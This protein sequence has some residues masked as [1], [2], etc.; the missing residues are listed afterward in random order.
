MRCRSSGMFPALILTSLLFPCIAMPAWQSLPAFDAPVIAPQSAPCWHQ[1]ELY[2]VGRTS[3]WTSEDHEESHVALWVY[4]D[5]A[6]HV[7]RS[8]GNLSPWLLASDGTEL[9]V[10]D[11][12]ELHWLRDRRWR[13]EEVRVPGSASALVLWNGRVVAGGEIGE[14]GT[15]G[16]VGVVAWNGQAWASLGGGIGGVPLPRVNAMMADGGAVWVAGRFERA[17]DLPA[18]NVAR[19]DGIGWDDLG[20][21]ADGEI[22]AMAVHDGGVAVAGTFTQI[23][24]RACE[25]LALWRDGSWI[26]LPAPSVPTLKSADAC[27]LPAVTR[28]VSVR[29]GLLALGRFS[30]V[31]PS[32]ETVRDVAVLVDGKWQ[33][34]LHAH[35]LF[36]SGEQ[37]DWSSLSRRRLSRIRAVAGEGDGGRVAISGE[38]PAEIDLVAQVDGNID[39]RATWLLYPRLDR[40]ATPRLANWGN[41]LLLLGVDYIGP[42]RVGGLGRL[43]TDGWEPIGDWLGPDGQSGCA[44]KS[45]VEW[46]GQ[47]VVAGVFD[48]VA[49]RPA[50]YVAAFDGHAWS[51]LAGGVPVE[52]VTAV[53][54]LP[55]RR[56]LVVMTDRHAA[57]SRAEVRL[58]SWDG[59]AWSP[60][61]LP[62]LLA[63]A[64][65]G[66]RAVAADDTIWVVA[67]IPDRSQAAFIGLHVQGMFALVDTSWTF[68]GR[69]GRS[70]PWELAHWNG[71]LHGL[72]SD[73]SGRVRTLMRWDGRDWMPADAPALPHDESA[74]GLRALADGRLLITGR[75][76]SWCVDG[77]GGW[78]AWPGLRVGERWDAA[79][80]GG[81]LFR[82]AADHSGTAER[83]DGALPEPTPDQRPAP[84]PFIPW[85][86]PGRI[87]QPGLSPLAACAPGDSLCGWYIWDNGGTEELARARPRGN[88]GLEI[89]GRDAGLAWQ[90]HTDASQWYR[91]TVRAH[92]RS[93]R[94]SISMSIQEPGSQGGAS[95]RFDFDPM[96][97][98]RPDLEILVPARDYGGNGHVVFE[99]NKGE[100]RLEDP[101]LEAGPHLLAEA[102][103]RLQEQIR[104]CLRPRDDGSGGFSAD[105]SAAARVFTV[106]EAD[107]VAMAMIA[108]LGDDRLWVDDYDGRFA[109]TIVPGP[110]PTKEGDRRYESPRSTMSCERLPD[111]VTAWLDGDLACATA[112]V[113]SN[114]YV[115]DGFLIPAM[116]GL[117]ARG[118][119]VDLREPSARRGVAP[120]N[121][122][123]ALRVLGSGRLRWARE[124]DRDDHAH[125]WL[126]AGVGTGKM[127][128][129][130]RIDDMPIVVFVS[131]HTDRSRALLAEALAR[132]DNVTLIGE[133]TAPLPEVDKVIEVP[134][135]R[136]KLMVPS[137]TWEAPG[138]RILTGTRVVPDIAWP[139][140]DTE[141]LVGQ[142]RA[143]VDAFVREA[144][145]R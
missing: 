131:G 119:V 74:G 87:P 11:G 123:G 86:R 27:P 128:P 83:W 60:I 20:G 110:Q 97:P 61:A 55:R 59:S 135:S 57:G 80:A 4:R 7:V 9:V 31:D 94:P 51:N 92:R 32:G 120:G 35:E 43:G 117:N 63:E 39:K 112:E 111:G 136:W 36:G 24:G 19:W 69:A 95:C 115:D 116:A 42:S 16:K 99:V 142:A 30:F 91:L 137:G 72:V 78:A 14:R 96:R 102:L 118:L 73:E 140:A 121:V 66:W 89:A 2:L 98:R 71:A 45:A 130:L 129:S 13:D 88:G 41:D 47:L 17:G 28:L 106:A 12:Q 46:R 127:K 113:P 134:W 107:S 139:A 114:W 103:Q 76:R 56:D 58:S 65:T 38:G 53:Q 29:E 145:A 25:G 68:L 18:G 5:G 132:L 70:W 50:R 48:A 141:G 84:T 15:R 37:E 79:L 64:S 105:L 109:D 62:P 21:G 49:G 67:S 44:V 124:R 122:L 52:S 93:G 104:A 1:G 34:W 100:L 6:W 26:P 144:R 8:L 54:M 23:G 82:L 133:T 101:R 143:V 75:S 40:A 77:A 90:F 10:M 125:R 138:G 85:R 126:E 108:G 22:V 3:E 81:R 33:R